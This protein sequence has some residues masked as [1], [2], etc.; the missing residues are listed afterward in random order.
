MLNE[1]QIVERVDRLTIQSL[2]I[3][4]RE[5]W[6][7]PR[8][9]ADGPIFDE[10]DAARAR[11]ICELRHDMNLNDDAIP[12]V[13]S[14]LDQLHGARIHIKAL[15]DAID[16]QPQHVRDSVKVAIQSNVSVVR[17]DG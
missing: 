11:L 8:A 3:W 12:V 4:V 17:P 10:L 6:I 13:L 7:A 15:V 1:A 16:D 9:T 14:L 5:G 2:R